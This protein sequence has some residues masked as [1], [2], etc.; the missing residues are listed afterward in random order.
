MRRYFYFG[1]V[2]ASLLVAI[3]FWVTTVHA[4]RL[5]KVTH[6]ET[7][8]Y[9]SPSQSSRVLQRLEKSRY[10][11]ASNIPTRGFYKVRTH[12]GNIGWIVDEALD[13]KSVE[14]ISS[15]AVIESSE[16]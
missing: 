4:A 16:E 14:G 11:T 7:E 12:T 6:G 5:A 10:V 1:F 15:S 8:V 9:E 2:S 3:V 13:F